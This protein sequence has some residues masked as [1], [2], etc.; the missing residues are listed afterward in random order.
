MPVVTA[1]S[2][3]DL[4]I[5]AEDDIT[6][7][8]TTIHTQTTTDTDFDI[9]TE[10]K[11]KAKTNTNTDT[12]TD[13]DT[14]TNTETTTTTQRKGVVAA[15]TTTTTKTTPPADTS[16]TA[17]AIDDAKGVK[18]KC[19][20]AGWTSTECQNQSQGWIE[21]HWWAFIIVGESNPPDLYD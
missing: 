9:D 10:T 2:I 17:G 6:A 21:T 3:A 19:S 12:D 15:D 8:R 5:R 1:T 20:S 14:N 11:T 13:T 4:L 16:P 18:A 7:H